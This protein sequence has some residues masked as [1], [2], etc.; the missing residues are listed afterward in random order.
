MYADL[1]PFVRCPSCGASPLTL[2]GPLTDPDDGEIVAGALRCDECLTQTA[3]R[4]GI[5][6]ALD[7]HP[8]PMTP[9]QITNYSPVTAA[10][11]E[12]GWRWWALTAMSGRR[13][14]LPEELT[15]LRDL[16]DPQPGRLYLDVAC[17]AGLYARVLARSGAIVAGIDHSMAFMREAR[18]KARAQGLRISYIRGSA[19]HLP[20]AD[21][22]AAGAVMGGSLNE[23]GDQQRALDEISRTL[24]SGGRFFCMSLNAAQSGWGRALQQALGTGGIVFPSIDRLNMW[25]DQAQMRRRA[26]WR[27]RVV[28]ITLAERL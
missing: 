8:V 3:I 12:P 22:G 23:I 14:P 7:D 10:I 5:W 2:L 11:Y 17:S 26:Q 20:F 21:D 1:L 27:W 28:T 19:Q 15:L 13:F 9:A 18:R 24:E 4:D 16:I 25:L 6:N